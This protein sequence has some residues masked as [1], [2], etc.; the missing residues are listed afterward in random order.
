MKF[1]Y[2][3]Q[4][5]RVSVIDKSV[6]QGILLHN[7]Y[8]VH[9]MT[10]LFCSSSPSKCKTCFCVTAAPSVRSVECKNVTDHLFCSQN[11]QTKMCPQNANAIKLNSLVSDI[12]QRQRCLKSPRY[13]WHFQESW[14]H[15]LTCC[16]AE[17]L[18]KKRF[19]LFNPTLN[20]LTYIITEYK[21]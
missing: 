16:L 3:S 18:S 6:F 9:E 20:D 2:S 1:L 13:G 19:V 11:K 12:R 14:F 15:H 7:F 4:S 17:S 21:M 10:D 8:N 5:L